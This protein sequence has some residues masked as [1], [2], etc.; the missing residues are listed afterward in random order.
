MW[1]MVSRK[2]ATRYKQ[3]QESFLGDPNAYTVHSCAICTTRRSSIC[4]NS[5]LVTSFL[6]DP[7]FAFDLHSTAIKHFLDMFT[8]DKLSQRSSIRLRSVS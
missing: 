4:S 3:Q 7:L 8:S 1:P 2:E 6:S 5:L